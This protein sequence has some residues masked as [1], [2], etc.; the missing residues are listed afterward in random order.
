MN[1]LHVLILSIVEGITEFLPI[2]STGHLIL[3]SKLL[4]ITP[5]DFSKTFDIAIQLGA[6]M[7]VV[8]LYYKKFI[9]GAEIYKKLLV[10]FIPSALV[11]L[12]LYPFIKGFLLGS[13][14]I[15]LLSLF[16][17]GLIL[18]FYDSIQEICGRKL[19]DE[20]NADGHPLKQIGN[21][22]RKV[23]GGCHKGRNDGMERIGYKEALKIGIFQSISVVPGVS[24]AAATILGGMFSGLSR[25]A[26]VEF[27]FLLAV[28]TMF[29]AT[30]L[31]LYKSKDVLIS[32]D[33]ATLLVGM[34]LSFIFA[35][36]AIKFLI[37]YVK[38]HDFTSFGVYRILLA[39]LFWVLVR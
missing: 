12:V 38:K 25:K 19:T 24:R 27:S 1:L 30:A 9:Q 34:T 33:I 8:V 36:F 15:T 14:T 13:S 35:M 4:S 32:S 37:G 2:S 7:A 23:V 31:D 39:V 28:P 21:S 3:A 18:I 6:I 26:A 22:D 29:A 20:L 11:G 17:G 10:A 5:S 16:L